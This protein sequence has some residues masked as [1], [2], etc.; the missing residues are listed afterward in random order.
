MSDCIELQ[1]YITSGT[2]NSK[3]AQA[4]LL[5]AL[6]QKPAGRFHLQLIDLKNEPLR[7]LIDGIV[8]IPTL[9]RKVGLR[10]DRLIGNLSD[11]AVLDTFL[12][13]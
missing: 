4:Q 7:A 9:Q 3:Q 12:S 10:R 11:K 2:A 13:G 1:L 8:A 6:E 5:T